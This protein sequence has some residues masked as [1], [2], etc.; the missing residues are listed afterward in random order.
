M[1]QDEY[2]FSPNK[3]V[4]NKLAREVQCFLFMTESETNPF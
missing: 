3:Y 2:I 1:L 4:L